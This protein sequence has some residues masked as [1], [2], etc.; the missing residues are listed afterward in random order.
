MSF[1]TNVLKI[2]PGDIIG[3]PILKIDYPTDRSR[4]AALLPPG[5]E[6]TAESNVH[7]SI[8]NYPVPDE[9]E[10]GIVI[11]VDAAYRGTPGMYTIAYGIDQES[12]VYISKETNGQPKYLAEI[13][14]YRVGPAVKARCT[15]HGY[16]FLEF[17][18]KTA[19]PAP[20]PATQ[21]EHEWWIKVSRAVGGAE[22]SYDFPPHV[23]MVKAD[24]KPVYREKVEGELKLLASPWD[25]IAD[26]LPVRGAVSAYLSWAM[27]TSRDITLEGKLDPDAFWAHVDT[28]GS[29]RWPG[30]SGGP[31]RAR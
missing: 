9:P 11:G 26:L 23:V 24:Y 1:D 15:H 5:L 30:T 18:G 31:R 22:K 2:N 7:L 25:P 16:T 13:E 19:G 17:S 3:W 12:A 21:L 4:I 20:L 29:S 14:Y 28:I 6:P 8:Y 27:P 10:Y